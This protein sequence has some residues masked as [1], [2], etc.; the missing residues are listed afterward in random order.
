ML[1][2]DIEN[3]GEVLFWI[4]VGVLS[5]AVLG[6]ILAPLSAMVCALLARYKGVE[7]SYAA[8]GAKHS[9]LLVLP[10][11]YLLTRLMFG[12]SPVPKP[13]VATV[14]ILLYS[15]WFTLIA[16]YVIGLILHVTDIL[17]THSYSL[18]PALV[19]LV[20]NGLILPIIVFACGRSMKNL[21]RA[22]AVQSEVAHE[23]TTTLPSGAY[24]E[25]FSSLIAW[26]IITLAIVLIS[27]LLGFIGT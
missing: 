20:L 17:V 25:P 13:V 10:F 18:G 14:F 19:G 2:Q 11:I 16:I 21:R 15:V 9:I 26:S 8:A 22:G 7:G 3:F 23:S 4:P 12:R 27:G 6:L 1:T 5:L 24:L